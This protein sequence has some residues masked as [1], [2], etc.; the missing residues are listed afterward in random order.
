VAA[1]ASPGTR[2]GKGENKARR[3]VGLAPP[4]DALGRPLDAARSA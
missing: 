4:R 1:I 2:P 3:T